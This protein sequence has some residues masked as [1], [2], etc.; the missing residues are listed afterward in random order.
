MTVRKEIQFDGMAIF[1]C[2]SLITCSLYL[3]KKS[4]LFGSIGMKTETFSWVFWVSHSLHSCSH[5]KLWTF[6]IISLRKRSHLYLKRSSYMGVH[7]KKSGLWSSELWLSCTFAGFVL[8]T[9]C[10]DSSRYVLSSC[11]YYNFSYSSMKN[12]VLFLATQYTW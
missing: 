9:C 10:S 4:M 11:F 7:L 8:W 3:K 12:K 2:F 6:S 1:Q 5:L